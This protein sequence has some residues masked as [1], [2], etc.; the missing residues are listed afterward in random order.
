MV[1]ILET[2]NFESICVAISIATILYIPCYLLVFVTRYKL[3]ITDDAIIKE[4]CVF[5]IK[6]RFYYRDIT[7]CYYVPKSGRQRYPKLVVKR[8]FRIKV[9]WINMFPEQQELV[10]DLKK[11]IKVEVY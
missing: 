8:G 7:K 4:N 10:V 2:F 5:K 3:Y 11:H 1:G 6:R 9:F